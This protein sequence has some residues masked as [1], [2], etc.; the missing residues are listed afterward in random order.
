MRLSFTTVTLLIATCASLVSATQD[1]SQIKAAVFH[2]VAAATDGQA[3]KKLDDLLTR[4]EQ[5]CP[6][7]Y[8]ICKNGVCCPMGG[9][10]CSN[11]RCCDKGWWCNGAGGCCR[12]DYN[13]CEGNHCCPKNWNCC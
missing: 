12:N 5:S 9:D 2:P 6:G 3:S 13:S 4:S 11:R 8:G 1:E 10:C 7:G